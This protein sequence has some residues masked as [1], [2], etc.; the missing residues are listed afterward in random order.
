M[1]KKIKNIE[2]I[3]FNKKVYEWRME[4]INAIYDLLD[5]SG[6]K[7]ITMNETFSMCND[8]DYFDATIVKCTYD[9]LGLTLYDEEGYD[10]TLGFFASVDSL[11]DFYNTLHWRLTGKL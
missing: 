3:N 8:C 10:Y 6:R 7:R 4:V 1:S 2:K 9:G 11:I 5:K